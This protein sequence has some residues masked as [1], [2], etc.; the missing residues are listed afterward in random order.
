MRKTLGTIAVIS[1]GGLLLA[2][3]CSNLFGTKPSANLKTGTLS[4]S[5][6]GAKGLSGARTIEP[7]VDHYVVDLAVNNP[8]L[9][10]D[11]N[12]GAAPVTKSLG[13][14]SSTITLAT[15]PWSL[16]LK[17]YGRNGALLAQG[18]TFFTLLPGPNIVPLALT[19]VATQTATGQLSAS[20]A[21]MPTNTGP[22][23]FFATAGVFSL[24]GSTSGHEFV[25]QTAFN[26]PTA[27]G[28]AAGVACAVDPYTGQATISASS[29]PSGEE[30][31]LTLSLYKGSALVTC[32]SDV[33]HIY[34]GLLSSKTTALSAVD[35]NAAVSTAAPATP[36]NLYFTSVNGIVNLWWTETNPTAP[37][38]IYTITRS[39]LGHAERHTGLSL[40]S[41]MF[42][43]ASPAASETITLQ[44]SNRVGSSAVVTVTYDSAIQASAVIT[45]VSPANGQVTVWWANDPSATYYLYYGSGTSVS[46]TSSSLGPLTGP[47]V[48]LSG[49]ANSTMQSLLLVA[50]ANSGSTSFHGQ[51]V[52]VSADIPAANLLANPIWATPGSW[53]SWGYSGGW[54][55][56]ANGGMN[57]GGYMMA[58]GGWD[59]H[60]QTVDLAALS[61]Y[62]PG[63]LQVPGALFSFSEWVA[64]YYSPGSYALTLDLLD[65]SSVSLATANDGTVGAPSTVSGTSYVNDFSKKSVSYVNAS[66]LAISKATVTGSGYYFT[67]F[68]APSLSVKVPVASYPFTGGSLADQSGN[69][70]TGTPAN[71]GISATTDRKSIAGN[72][73]SLPASLAG[74]NV[75]MPFS[76]ILAF[77]DSSSF[78]VS[79]WFNSAQTPAAGSSPSLLRL[80]GAGLGELGYDLSIQ[81]GSLVKG[82]VTSGGSGYSVTGA[83]TPGTWTHV[84][85]VYDNK[86][87]MLYINGV[88]AGV[89]QYVGAPANAAVA[90][91]LTLGGG[92]TDY[93]AGN[94]DDLRIYDRAL[95][96]SEAQALSTE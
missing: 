75:T 9:G 39:S 53:F 87:V 44:A 69:S 24:V 31:V 30:Y 94:L 42:Y 86:Q 91:Y 41:C 27:F 66:G 32:L 54:S 92:D 10:T 81:N 76:P 77:A 51:P 20:F 50:V 34:D 16:S 46:T 29:L 71:A 67:T 65:A 85:M 60:L 83:Y 96:V 13:D 78:S 90:G 59:S 80:A 70:V 7:F 2:T 21:W 58:G 93:Y 17:S 1:L 5:L 40:A 22:G 43:V 15:G 14:P 82:E 4:I 64:P 84:V 11:A 95:S 79:L 72:A 56:N 62:T 23:D 73:V 57:L 8:G 48:T 35:L 19:A 49:L 89:T 6:P 47:N 52:K 33:V 88:S 38:L 37:D 45:N 18:T 36:T 68:S 28:S 61:G 26:T 3:S 74:P 63:Q 55:G 25:D 12:Y